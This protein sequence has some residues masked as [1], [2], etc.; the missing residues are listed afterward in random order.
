MM[1]EMMNFVV[2]V[3]GIGS[4]IALFVSNKASGKSSKIPTNNTERVD[5]DGLLK[6]SSINKGVSKSKGIP[7]TSA[8]IRVRN[9]NI[10]LDQFEA[11][12]VPLGI[13]LAA[14]VN[15]NYESRLTAALGDSSSGTPHSFGLFQ[16]NI[17]GAGRGMTA[18]EMLD[19]T[20]NTK[21]IIEDYQKNGK[22]LRDAYFSGASV[23]SLSGLFGKYIERPSDA[24]GALTKRANFARELFPSIADKAGKELY[25]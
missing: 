25:R 12:G 23:S 2:P 24:E 17:Y 1:C 20:A 6:K 15:A 4:L 13:S 9:A 11:A 22:P 18:A 7:K 3:V 8:S 19:P 16:L 21:R 10:V 14:L 5:T